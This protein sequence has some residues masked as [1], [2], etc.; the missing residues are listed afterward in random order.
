MGKYMFLEVEIMFR[1]IM[2]KMTF[3]VP[4]MAS[5][6]QKYVMKHPGMSV[7]GSLRLFTVTAFG[8]W[9]AGQIIRTRTGRMSGTRKMVSIGQ[10]LRLKRYGKNAMNLQHSFLKIKFG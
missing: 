9:L 4:R 10:S 5:I 1:I 3:G 6:G 2:R 7:Y 8:L